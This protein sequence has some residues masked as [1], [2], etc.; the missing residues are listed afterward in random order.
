MDI[1]SIA[2]PEWISYAI[3]AAG[4]ALMATEFLRLILRGEAAPES[5]G[6]V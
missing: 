3:L 6:G 2:I 5:H 1:R 4:F